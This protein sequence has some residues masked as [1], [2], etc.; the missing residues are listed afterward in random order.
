MGDGS[1]FLNFLNFRGTSVPTCRLAVS[2]SRRLTSGPPV[3]EATDSERGSVAPHGIGAWT[4]KQGGGRRDRDRVVDELGG[5]HHRGAAHRDHAW[6]T[7]RAAHGG[8]RGGSA[9]GDSSR[10]RGGALLRPVVRYERHVAR[11]L[12]ACRSRAGRC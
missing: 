12:T 2:P 5:K 3:Y 7:C 6:L 1:N 4:G 9:Q 8:G 11:P 10:R